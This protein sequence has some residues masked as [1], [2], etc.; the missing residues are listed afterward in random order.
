MSSMGY[1][2]HQIQVVQTL[3][4]DIFITID[5]GTIKYS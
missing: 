2:Q 1:P 4:I 3:N 5:N